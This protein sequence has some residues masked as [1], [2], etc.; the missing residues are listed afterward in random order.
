MLRLSVK[1]MI[2]NKWLMLSLFAGILLSVIIACSIPI[3]SAGISNR[4]LVTQLQ[5]YQRNEG[6]HPGTFRVSTSI[7]SFKAG[8]P[9]KNFRS[10][11]DYIQEVLIPS[12]ALPTMVNS[13]C[14]STNSIYM[15]D[16]RYETEPGKSAPSVVVRALDNYEGSIKMVK[17]RM[18]SAKLDEDGYIEVMVSRAAEQKLGVVLDKTYYV[19]TTSTLIKKAAEANRITVKVVGVFDY[20]GYAYTGLSDTDTGIE[21]YMNYEL[22]YKEL[23]VKRDYMKRATWYF[24]GDYSSLTTEQVLQFENALTSLQQ[25]TKTSGLSKE[26]LMPPLDV[27]QEF[28]S[29]LTSVRLL[30][31]MFYIPILILLIF[32]IFMI[33]KLVV[34]ND[35]NELSVLRS[36][37]ASPRQLLSI[38]FIQ[39]GILSGVSLVLAPLIALALCRLL[40]ATSG[41]LE[42]GQRAP[43]SLHISGETLLYG[44]A[45]AV[46]VMVT[47]IVPALLASRLEIVEQKQQKAKKKIKPLW[48]KLYLDIVLLAVA[49]YGYYNYLSQRSII[50]AT[51]AQAGTVTLD[52]L[53]YLLIVLFLI[54][55]GMLFLR[56]YPLGLMLGFKASKARL[57]PPLYSGLTRIGRMQGREQFLLLFLV[58]TIAMGF[59][60]ANSAR[61]INVNMDEKVLY[62][63]GTDMIVTPSFEIGSGVDTVDTVYMR[64]FL[65]NDIDDVTAAAKVVTGRDPQ[66]AFGGKSLKTNVNLMGIHPHQFAQVAWWRYGISQKHMNDYLNLLS[67][68]ADG[69]ILSK[70]AAEQLNVGVGSMVYLKPEGAKAKVLM[71]TVVAIVDVWPTYY[72]TVTNTKGE[73]EDNYLIVA[74]LAQIEGEVQNLEYQ[75]WLKTDKVFSATEM[76]KIMIDRGMQVKSI[77]NTKAEYE[78]SQT[79]AVRQATNGA[80]T[81]GFLVIILVCAIGFIIYWVLSIKGRVLQIGTMRAL[82]MPIRQVYQMIFW[83]QLLLAGAGVLLG[84]VLGGA[85]SSLFVPMLQTAFGA[86]D[87]VP[88]FHIVSAAADFI[89]IY[90][91]IAA[92]LALGMGLALFMLRQ[93]KAAAAIK[94]GEE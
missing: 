44:L 63:G 84:I 80:L 87:Q 17:G 41:F 70:N 65:F 46:L 31:V 24:V 23:L 78:N 79:S 62:K 29:A 76:S 19:N 15:A 85:A 83:E 43:I 74:N 1:K 8:S 25:W 73:V 51:N 14:L 10:G 34:D 53:N 75:A 82:G 93:I 92:L 68:N 6:I 69:C 61:T 26:T 13:T 89:K 67:E 18:P 72:P 86:A 38:Y 58:M 39:S 33:T 7:S 90:A 37:G 91:F 50:A 55:A 60:S 35:R 27:V 88:P 30:L 2:K 20:S 52:P 5:N 40:G 4:M 12:L 47:M 77:V 81:L 42:F 66:L 64:P 3:Y 56:L 49:G 57:R 28:S 16:T 9:E 11:D 48:Q 45:A 94:L 32:F 54:G 36:R 71:V 22:A 59:F 21:M